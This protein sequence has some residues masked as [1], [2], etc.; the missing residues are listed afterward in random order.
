[1]KALW[2]VFALL[3]GLTAAQPWRPEE[4]V[5]PK[6]APVADLGKLHAELRRH[7]LQNGSRAPMPWRD[8]VVMPDTEQLVW[9]TRVL[10]WNKGRIT[11]RV[12]LDPN[13]RWFYVVR[14]DRR[15]PAR[16]FGPIDQLAD[17][18]FVDWRSG[19]R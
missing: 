4:A 15:G 8:A 12:A 10:R 19:A 3:P 7:L 5:R 18:S 2:L 14:A 9:S 17:G 1:M 13:T 11:Y 6:P 16:Y